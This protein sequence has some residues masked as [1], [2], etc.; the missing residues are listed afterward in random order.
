MVFSVEVMHYRILCVNQFVDVGHEITNDFC[1]GFVDL[2]K[3]LDVGD[4]LFV[5]G[6][7]IVIFDT[8]KGVAVLESATY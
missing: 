7:D 3:Q 8:C 4:S 1:V 6:D 2:L 5:V